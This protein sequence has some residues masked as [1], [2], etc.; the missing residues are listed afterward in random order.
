MAIY[1]TDDQVVMVNNSNHIIRVILLLIKTDHENLQ[2]RKTATL[3]TLTHIVHLT[4][5]TIGQNQ[6]SFNDDGILYLITNQSVLL[7]IKAL[8]Y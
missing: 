7:H 8:C 4:T 6:I 2:L 5:S 3:S 1:N